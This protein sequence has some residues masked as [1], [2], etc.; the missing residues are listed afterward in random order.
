M[1]PEDKIR[2]QENFQWF[3]QYF[4]DIRQLVKDIYETLVRELGYNAGNKGWYYPKSNYIPSLPPYWVIASGEKGFTLQIYLIQDTS[5]L[6]THPLFTDDISLIFVKHDRSDKVLWIEEFGMRVI[7]NSGIK[8]NIINNKYISGEI[9]SNTPSTKYQ[10]FQVPI[11][12]F[13][14]GKDIHQVI[15]DEVVSVLKELPNWE[16]E[17]S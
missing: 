2:F 13:T 16:G 8:Y 11:S 15:L 3:N 17:K 10:A 14:E 4:Q 12:A 1:L 9:V 7:K 5:L 6:S